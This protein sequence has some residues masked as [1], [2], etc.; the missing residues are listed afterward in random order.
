MSVTQLGTPEVHWTL[1]TPS[2]PLLRRGRLLGCT[3]RVPQSGFLSSHLWCGFKWDRAWAGWGGS[4]IHTGL[5][6][7]QACSL[8]ETRTVALPLVYS[9]GEACLIQRGA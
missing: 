9:E 8:K 2:G 3:Q 4:L 7:G 1:C 6:V 5:A